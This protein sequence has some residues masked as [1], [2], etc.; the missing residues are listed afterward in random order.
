MVFLPGT[1]CADG[2]NILLTTGSGIIAG[3]SPLSLPFACLAQWSGTVRGCLKNGPCRSTVLAT[4]LAGVSIERAVT[5]PHLRQQPHQQPDTARNF[6]EL[7]CDLIEPLPYSPT[8]SRSGQKPIGI[9]AHDSSSPSMRRRRFVAP[10]PR[11]AGA[12]PGASNA[13][14]MRRDQFSHLSSSDPDANM[15]SGHPDT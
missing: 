8:S 7:H 14:A 9:A 6:G 12:V 5:A 3:I 15:M 2:D 13:R 4:S 1:V 10:S 11:S